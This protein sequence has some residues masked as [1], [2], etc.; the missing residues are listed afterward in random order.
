MHNAIMLNHSSPVLVHNVYNG[1]QTAKINMN[2]I[3]NTGLQYQMVNNQSN[4]QLARTTIQLNNQQQN[5][6]NT[7]I[8]NNTHN[9]NNNNGNSNNN[10]HNTLHA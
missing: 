10:R 4:T 6:K 9:K 7:I 2:T 1:S 3:N 8:N 5:H